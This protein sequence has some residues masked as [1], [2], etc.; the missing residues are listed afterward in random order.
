MRHGSG[1][2]DRRS[3]C[4]AKGAG[5]NSLSLDSGPALFIYI[6][7]KDRWSGLFMTCQQ[8]CLRSYWLHSCEGLLECGGIPGGRKLIYINCRIRCWNFSPI[9][10]VEV[11]CIWVLCLQFG[12]NALLRP[13][14]RRFSKPS[15]LL[16]RPPLPSTPLY[17]SILLV[18]PLQRSFEQFGSGF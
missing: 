16:R 4:R 11:Y 8:S 2:R 9:V 5:N 3:R 18:T 7:N 17:R 14:L 10:L 12:Y 13:P 15:T 1:S 6:R